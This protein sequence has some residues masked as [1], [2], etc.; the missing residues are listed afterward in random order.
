MEA[1]AGLAYESYAMTLCLLPDHE[2]DD[3]FRIIRHLGSAAWARST[4]RG[5]ALASSGWRSRCFAPPRW[6]TRS[7]GRAGLPR[8]GRA[9]ARVR[10]PAIVK[11]LEIGAGDTAYVA[12]ELLEG[13]D[14]AQRLER[15]GPL[16]LPECEQL[17]RDLSEA[18]IAM[19]E[20]GVVH[21]DLKPKNVF[22]AR[23]ADGGSQLKVLDFGLAKANFLGDS[24]TEVQQI[25]GTLNYLS[26]EQL[27]SATFADERSDIWA[28]GAVL[29]EALT[30]RAAFPGRDAPQGVTAISTLDAPSAS[31]LRP[32]LP[33][34]LSSLVRRSLQR[35]T[36]MRFGSARALRAALDAHDVPRLDEVTQPAI[37]PVAT[38]PP[39]TRASRV[40]LLG[41]L[42][43]SGVCFWLLHAGASRALRRAP[44]ARAS[45]QSLYEF[46]ATRE[47]FPG[48]LL[49][50]AASVRI[51]AAV[52]PMVP[53]EAPSPS[54]SPS[55]AAKAPGS[56]AQAARARG[57]TH[58]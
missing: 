34:R 22:L 23:A 51:S 46:T 13:E 42:V 35:D 7:R 2:V 3:R 8:E 16:P 18:L 10:H 58:P 19:H 30:G 43:A 31:S 26:P 14:L 4:R 47:P 20:A 54:P 53:V 45:D 15:A 25:F 49:R 55:P 37:A 32:E 40:W 41:A 1:G 36:T 57:S 24:L 38:L 17:A 44:A 29:F 21:R 50:A 48:R 6:R 5:T 28:F 52:Q 33:E 56:R 27:R 11:V 12:M 9:A 39:P